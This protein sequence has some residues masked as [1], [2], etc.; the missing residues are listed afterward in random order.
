MSGKDFI[1]K[2]KKDG[3][4]EDRINGSHHIFIKNGVSLAVPTLNRVFLI[5]C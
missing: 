4:V 2:L 1:K 3:W 5:H